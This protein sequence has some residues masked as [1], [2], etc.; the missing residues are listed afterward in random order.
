MPKPSD[1]CEQ[2]IERIHQLLEQQGSEVTWNDHLP[3][4][5]NPSQPR[6]IDITI[7][8]EGKLTL[9]ECRIHKEKQ[10]VTWIEELIG[11]RAS[12]NADAVIAV[13]ASGFTDGAIKK[14]KA[15]GII[16]RDLL[17]LTKEEIAEWGHLTR[18]WVAF[19][20]FTNVS[21]IFLFDPIHINSISVEEI[22]EY[23][24]R[25]SDQLYGIF[26]MVAKQINDENPRGHHEN[27][28]V[29]LKS[30]KLK[31]V[32]WPI[33]GLDFSAKFA[34]RRQELK[35]AS[36][37]AYDAPSIRATERSAF[38]EKVDVGDFEITQSSNNVIV[39]L[40]LTPI[41]I[42]PNCKFHGVDFDFNR[43]VTMHGLEIIGFP[44]TKIAL[45]GIFVSFAE[46][47]DSITN[48]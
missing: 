46:Y 15:F 45:K 19:Y 3:D 13:S 39:T 26:E 23:L 7:K 38:V 43:V 4:P 29:R 12:L 44:R 21:L 18:V 11:R 25:E 9:V 48:V 20:E 32:D 27:F 40:D 24:H 14:A 10:D 17:T 36:V 37:V 42:P 30:N 1:K 28:A 22:S 16:L 5:D 41:E 33:A 8:R 31:I 34:L 35:I 2:Q 47:S 6:Q